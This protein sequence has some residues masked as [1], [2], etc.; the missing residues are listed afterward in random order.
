MN[1][2]TLTQLIDQVPFPAPGENDYYE[3]Q[4]TDGYAFLGAAR[5]RCGLPV[6][7]CRRAIE[8]LDFTLQA[9]KLIGDTPVTA[10]NY[11]AYTLW[12]CMEFAI[13]ALL[14]SDFWDEIYNRFKTIGLYPSGLARYCSEEINLFVPNAITA[15]A[16]IYASM[17]NF[18]VVEK[19][20]W[21]LEDHQRPDG[22]WNYYTLDESHEILSVPRQEDCYH[23]AM[24]LYQ[25]REIGACSNLNVLPLQS[26]ILKFLARA[27]PRCSNCGKMLNSHL[28]PGS[29]GWGVP[30]TLVAID[31][32]C[33]DIPVL[34]TA[35]LDALPRL[36][37]EYLSAKNFRVRAIAAWAL[38]KIYE[39]VNGGSHDSL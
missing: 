15:A 7:D 2:E 37:T 3:S 13:A 26:G 11:Y 1:P 10:K 36:S 19:L 25:L 27:K 5:A 23:L 8:R 17:D 29:I 21:L 34:Y 12:A 4:S 30:M 9:A 20:F 18:K 33:Q 14:G 38:T 39:R 16:M 22:N 32:I 35:Y 28:C 24:M 31:G 6:D